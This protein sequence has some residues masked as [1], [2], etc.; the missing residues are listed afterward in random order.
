MTVPKWI[1][2]RLHPDME[3]DDNVLQA[4]DDDQ[5]WIDDSVHSSDAV[6]VPLDD[7]LVLNPLKMIWDCKMLSCSGVKNTESERWT[8]GWC[9]A[10]WNKWNTMKALKHVVGKGKGIAYCKKV[11]KGKFKDR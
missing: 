1:S 5:L 4:L 7:E 9:K 11:K 8:C 3:E 6:D 10:T 2:L